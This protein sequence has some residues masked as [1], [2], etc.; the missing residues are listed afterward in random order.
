MLKGWFLTLVQFVTYTLLAFGQRMVLA[1]TNKNH[2]NFKQMM[3]GVLK[4]SLPLLVFCQI[5][6]WSVATIALSN[7]SL[8]YLS[9]PVQ[10]VFKSCKLIPVMLMGKCSS[11]HL[12][13]LF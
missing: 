1:A 12:C 13:V 7:A 2:A 4:R 5:S 9:Y 11:Y 3:D 8:L 6:F 10:V